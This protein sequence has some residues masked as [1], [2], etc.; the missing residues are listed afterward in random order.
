MKILINILI[1]F[2]L[3]NQT[4]AKDNIMILKIKDGEVI[5]DYSKIT[6]DLVNDMIKSIIPM[7]P[8]IHLKSIQTPEIIGSS[9]ENRSSRYFLNRYAVE[10]RYLRQYILCR[11]G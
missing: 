4:I 10:I 1:F 5:C 6:K 7:G 3:T 9:N 8:K 2:F 11:C